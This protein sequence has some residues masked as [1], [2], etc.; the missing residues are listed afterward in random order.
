MNETAYFSIFESPIGA[1]LLTS[2]GNAL[3]GLH[4]EPHPAFAGCPNDGVLRPAREQLRAYFAGRLGEFDVPLALEGTPFQQEV[5]SALRKIGYGE[6][7]SYAELARRVGRPGAA[8][9]CGSANGCNPVAIIV[10][11]H[12]VIAADGTL[13]GYGGG[14]DRKTWLLQH[15]ARNRARTARPGAAVRAGRR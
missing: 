11:C 4:M 12:R 1:L 13:G 8:R 10:P 3:T 14:L 15:E 9:A 6:T 2:D 7:I 5:W